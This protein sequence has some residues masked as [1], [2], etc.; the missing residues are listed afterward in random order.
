MNQESAKDI[1]SVAVS[2]WIEIFKI[3]QG[4]KFQAQEAVNQG[5]EWKKTH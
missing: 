4:Y 1:N 2:M 5:I 3:K